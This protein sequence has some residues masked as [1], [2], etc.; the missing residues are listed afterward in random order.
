MINIGIIRYPG[1]NCDIET[2]KYFTFNNTNCFYIWHKENNVNILNDL[3]LL[4]LLV[5]LLLVIE[6]IIKPLINILF[7]PEQWL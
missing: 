2:K 5:V 1:S 4:V 7:H 6:Y 3:H